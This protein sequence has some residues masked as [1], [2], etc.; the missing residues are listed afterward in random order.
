MFV[1]DYMTRHPIMISPDTS[2][3][4]SQQIMTESN[5]RH[6]PVVGDGKRILGLIS[7]ERLRIPPTHLGS[8]NVWEISRYLNELRAKDVMVKKKDLITIDQN[9]T[10]ER[11]AQTM[12]NNKVGCLLVLEEDIVVGI[13][14]EIDMM[15]QL[16]ELLGGNEPGVRVTIRVPNIQGEL[17]KI[18]G[19]ISE[20]GWN[21]YASGGV[22]TPK[23]PSQWDFVIKVRD[24]TKEE[25]IAVLDK[26]DGQEIIDIR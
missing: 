25:L 21:I 6:L 18:S 23:D 7:R 9:A 14:T 8:L 3:A 1:K 5:I 15:T 16:T 24:V 4:E 20:Q 11:A 12:I 19:A 13:I 10:L 2:A 26:I 17:A 22:N